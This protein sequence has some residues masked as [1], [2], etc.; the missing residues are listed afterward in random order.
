MLAAVLDDL[1]QLPNVQPVT[2]LHASLAWEPPCETHRF[3]QGQQRERF[4][5]LA[6]GADATLV[7]APELHGQLLRW[8]G[9]VEQAGGRLLG[10]TLEAIGLTSDKALLGQWWQR[11][12]V[13]TPAVARW[14]G[15]SQGLRFPAVLKPRDGAGSTAT[16]L[17]RRPEEVP[18]CLAQAEAE[19]H[20]GDFVVQEFVRGKPASVAFLIGPTATVALLPASQQLSRDGRFH[21]QGGS[22]PLPVP[23]AERAVALGRRAVDA[24]AGLRGYVGVDLVLGAARDGS[25]DFAIEINPRLTT[26]YLGLRMVADT[27]LAGAML[28]VLG[29][30]APAIHW[31][32]REVTF[33]PDAG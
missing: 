4:F 10:S 7:I 15:S 16:F 17:V 25:Q 27:N 32:T 2:L 28:R 19:G 9:F 18:A 11:H 6:G 1:R 33:R 21:Y 13:P 24:V 23:L 20:D 5:D 26:S 29:G 22:L 8:A 30:E 14:Q 12:G 31:Q 3:K